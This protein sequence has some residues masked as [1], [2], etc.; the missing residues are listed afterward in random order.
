MTHLT[1]SNFNLS[2]TSTSDHPITS[3]TNENEN[4]TTNATENHELKR[5]V[6]ALSV[7]TLVSGK[8]FIL[9]TIAAIVCAFLAPV[10]AIA[11]GVIAGVFFVASIGLLAGLAHSGIQMDNESQI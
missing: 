3:L 10:A 8:I 7:S 4:T 2:T 5:K 1:N 6:I 11:L 9:A